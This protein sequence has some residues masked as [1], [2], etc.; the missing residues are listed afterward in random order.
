MYKAASHHPLLGWIFH[1][2]S[3]IP[4]LSGY[5]LRRHPKGTD[6]MLQK[7]EDSW[8]VINLRIIFLLDLEANNTYKC[9][10]IEAIRSAIE[11]VNIDTMKYT[12][13]QRSDV[14]HRIHQ[15]LLFDYQ[16]YL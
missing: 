2:K 9:I 6:V 16:Q 14:L 5:S 4:N 15:R 10:R 1:Q 13:P 7:I 11:H 8:D 12:R 3:E